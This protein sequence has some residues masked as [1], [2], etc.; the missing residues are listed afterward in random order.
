MITLHRDGVTV[1]LDEALYWSDELSWSPVEQTVETSV[2]G[3]PLIDVAAMTSGRPITLEPVGEEVWITR[4]DLEQLNA[5]AS[6]PGLTMDLTIRGTT[7]TVIWRHQDKPA[8]DCR[9]L[10]HFTDTQPGDIYVAGL[11]FM[12]P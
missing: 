2:E 12:E 3:A 1:E 9:P 7:R 8:V 4:A 11:K 5:W 6:Q 10:I